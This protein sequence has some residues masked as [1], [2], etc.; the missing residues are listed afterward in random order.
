MRKL[1]LIMIDGISADHFTQYRHHLPNLDFLAKRGTYVNGVT[2]EMCGTSCPGRTSI[3]AGVSPADHGIYANFIYDQTA[4][5]FRWANPYDVTCTTLPGYASAQGLDVANIGFGMVRPEDCAIN[6][7]P[8]W[9]DEMIMRGKDQTPLPADTKWRQA[10]QI[11]D[12]DQ[13]LSTLFDQGSLEQPVQPNKSPSHKLQLG[14]LADQQLLDIATA[15][16]ISEQAPDLILLEIA[17]TDYFLHKYGR[18]HDLTK[19]SM[20]TADAQIGQFLTALD[21]SDQLDKYHF[22]ILSDHGHAPA[23]NGLYVDNLLPDGT[24]WSSEGG[25][26]MVRKQ[27][28]SHGAEIIERLTD[29]QIELWSNDHLPE[30]IRDQ[31]L[32]FVIPENSKISFEAALNGSKEIFGPSKY[33]SNHGMRPGDR[34]DYRFCIFSGPDIRSQIIDHA[35]TIQIAPTMAAILDIQTDWQADPLPVF[36]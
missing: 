8:W 31:L 7:A 14:M 21:R 4:E 9:A 35:K 23:P 13:R 27:S 19:W 16:A 15:L 29:H 1:V 11:K 2:P 5:M 12:P 3:I 18:D 22:V 20:R 33:L 24:D 36:N 25:V 17:I 32:T 28:E 6:I 10:S 34:D 26:L 30:K